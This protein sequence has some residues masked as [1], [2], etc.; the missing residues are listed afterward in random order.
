MRARC[1]VNA[2][3]AIIVER[4]QSGTMRETAEQPA[5][6]IQRVDRERTRLADAVAGG[7][8]LRRSSMPSDS[9]TSA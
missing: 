3:L 6:E 5:R 1:L 7:P 2:A 4:E 8:T 9:V